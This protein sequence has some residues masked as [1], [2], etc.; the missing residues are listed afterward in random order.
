MRHSP[1]PAPFMRIGKSWWKTPEPS[2]LRT[3]PGADPLLERWPG[4]AGGPCARLSSGREGPTPTARRPLR[5]LGAGS[6]GDSGT[7]RPAWSR[8]WPCGVTL[9]T[10]QGGEQCSWGE[11]STYHHTETQTPTRTQSNTHSDRHT[12]G[13]F[14]PHSV[15][16]LFICFR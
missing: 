7:A 10:S 2:R 15:N 3:P 5:C 16:I 12:H 11:F 9:Q 1:H 6:G 14:S 13:P 8:G 4:G